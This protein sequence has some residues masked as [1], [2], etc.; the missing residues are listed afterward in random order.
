MLWFS[1][2][3]GEDNTAEQVP[4]RYVPLFILYGLML[5]SYLRLFFPGRLVALQSP[6]VVLT[7][8]NDLVFLHPGRAPQRLP[9]G[10]KALKTTLYSNRIFLVQNAYR[11]RVDA[12][13]Q[14]QQLTWLS[15]PYHQGYGWQPPGTTGANEHPRLGFARLLHTPT[16]LDT[17][18]PPVL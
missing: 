7:V 3:W 8:D 1:P 15:S 13:G 11:L 18:N 5:L 10:I 9:W 12:T 2:D 6:V 17:F 14:V 4:Y 16:P